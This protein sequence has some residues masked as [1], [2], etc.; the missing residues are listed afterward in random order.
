M[1]SPTAPLRAEHADLVE[2][3][4]A[5]R[6]TARMF[7]T[8]D[9]EERAAA[10]AAALAFLRDT[11]VPH[12]RVEEAVLYPAWEELIG[13][14]GAAATMRHDHAAIVARIERLERAAADDVPEVQELLFELHALISVHFDAEERIVLDAFDADPAAAVRLLDALRTAH[15]P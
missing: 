13:R 15:A 7:L 9:F 8:M 10:I 14:P 12:A 1:A 6:S 2:P 4:D 3:I 11:L 5:L